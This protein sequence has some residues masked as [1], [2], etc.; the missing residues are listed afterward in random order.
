M[1]ENK[2]SDLEKLLE[3]LKKRN[4]LTMIVISAS[5]LLELNQQELSQATKIG[6]NTLHIYGNNIYILLLL[7]VSSIWRHLQ[8]CQQSSEKEDLTESELKER[9]KK[10]GCEVF[11]LENVMRNTMVRV[12]IMY[13]YMYKGSTHLILSLPSDNDNNVYFMCYPFCRQFLVRQIRKMFGNTSLSM[14]EILRRPKKRLYPPGRV[15]QSRAQNPSASSVGRRLPVIHLP[16][17]H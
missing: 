12:D 13:N 5:S 7:I 16:R 4:H 3:D 2:Q 8:S 15:I 14:S 1:I 6:I 9:L 10:T 11:Q 17:T